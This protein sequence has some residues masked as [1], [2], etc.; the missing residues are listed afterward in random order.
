MLRHLDDTVNS[1]YDQLVHGHNYRPDLTE[2]VTARN[3]R[4][5]VVVRVDRLRLSGNGTEWLYLGIR[6]EDGFI[7]TKDGYQA[8]T[9]E[10]VKVLTRLGYTFCNLK[11]LKGV[12]I[13]NTLVHVLNPEYV[14]KEAAKDSTH[15][16][17]WRG[18]WFGSFGDFSGFCGVRVVHNS[19]SLCGVRRCLGEQEGALSLTDGRRGE[20]SN[21]RGGELSNSAHDKGDLS[22]ARSEE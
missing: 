4:N 20:L 1:S 13:D 3:A 5:T 21:T 8:P 9:E 15:N 19:N 22:V 10:E 7:K 11:L 12:G 14:Q 17:L 2:A 18:S 16:S 6:T